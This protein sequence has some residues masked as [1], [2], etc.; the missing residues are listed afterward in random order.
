MACSPAYGGNHV[1]LMSSGEKKE[2][3][4]NGKMEGGLWEGG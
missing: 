4:R 1:N 2:E 3:G